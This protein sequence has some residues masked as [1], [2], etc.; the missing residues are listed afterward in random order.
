MSSTQPPQLPTG[1]DLHGTLI[2]R[3]LSD[4]GIG[5]CGIAAVLGDLVYEL[6]LPGDTD[7][8]R[9]RLILAALRGS[10]WTAAPDRLDDQG[11]PVA[12]IDLRPRRL[13]RGRGTL[14]HLHQVLWRAGFTPHRFGPAEAFWGYVASHLFDDVTSP[15]YVGLHGPDGLASAEA[16]RQAQ[17]AQAALH[18]AGWSTRPALDH[19]FYASPPAA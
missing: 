2:H 15:P 5:H 12:R 18:E 9:M 7:P 1:S 14:G 8:E 10:D 19:S 16:S 13:P 11:R 6:I 17:A 4:A 3:V